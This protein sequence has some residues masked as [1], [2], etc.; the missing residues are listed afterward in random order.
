M[1]KDIFKWID[2]NKKK[3]EVIFFFYLCSKQA[4]FFQ[5]TAHFPD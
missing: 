1:N 3:N 4:F 2:R 5:P